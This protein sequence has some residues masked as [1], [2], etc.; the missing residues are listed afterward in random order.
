VAGQSIETSVGV[1]LCRRLGLRSDLK[2]TVVASWRLAG[3]PFPVLNRIRSRFLRVRESEAA[4]TE[5]DT[6]SLGGE[7]VVSHDDLRR[8]TGDHVKYTV[9]RN[10]C[11]GVRD[12][13]KLKSDSSL[14]LL[15]AYTA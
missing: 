4:G 5:V 11:V 14:C 6:S 3:M 12:E 7:N 2:M 8:D 1:Q 9:R 13:V 10:K 15:D